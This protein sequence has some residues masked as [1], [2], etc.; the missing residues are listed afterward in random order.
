MNGQRQ[1][2]AGRPGSYTSLLRTWQ[3]GDIVEVKIPM[4]FRVEG[5]KDD[6]KRVAVMYGPLVMAAVT[7]PGNL[8]S[9]IHPGDSD[10]L[11]A[12]KPIEGKPLEF[13]ASSNI[14][15]TSPSPAEHQQIHFKSQNKNSI[16]LN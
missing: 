16:L 8:F 7:Q 14:F 5:F 11:K 6:P 1:E 9:E 10:P 2:N 15:R 13:S 12:L 3:N 4:N